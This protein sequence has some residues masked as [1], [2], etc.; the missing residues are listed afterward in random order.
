MSDGR[1]LSSNGIDHCDQNTFLIAFLK[2]IDVRA[3]TGNK[4]WCDI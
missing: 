3:L 1:K 2:D 4:T